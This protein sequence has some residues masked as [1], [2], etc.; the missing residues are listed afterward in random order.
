MARDNKIWVIEKVPFVTEY[1]WFVSCARLTRD[2]PRRVYFDGE[3]CVGHS[4]TFE[5]AKKWCD[6]RGLAF[7]VE[8]CSEG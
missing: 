1:R 8:R 7:D 5:G 3:V 4:D 2:D 6:D